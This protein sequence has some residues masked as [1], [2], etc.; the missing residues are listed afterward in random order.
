L[1]I[2][3]AAIKHNTQL[4]HRRTTKLN[5]LNFAAGRCMSQ[6]ILTLESSVER[7]YIKASLWVMQCSTKKKDSIRD[8]KSWQ[9]LYSKT[10][11]VYVDTFTCI[12][13]R[14]WARE[15]FINLLVNNYKY[16]SFINYSF[17]IFS[18]R[19]FG[20]E[21]F[22]ESVTERIRSFWYIL[23]IT[24]VTHWKVLWT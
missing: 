19:I 14:T 1:K 15:I 12:I 7:Q 24:Y 5:I 13:C 6:S 18:Q 22:I 21:F 17:D 2:K 3:V 4:K 10:E 16:F 23:N 8:G 11:S 20:L 9:S